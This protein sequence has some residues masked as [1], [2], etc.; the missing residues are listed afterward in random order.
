MESPPRPESK[1]PRESK[2]SAVVA[3]A[4]PL[5]VALIYVGPFSSSRARSASS[6][7]LLT[8]EESQHLWEQCNALF[9]Q[10]K[11][12]EAL[13][14]VLKLHENYP[15]NHIYLEMAAEI[16]DRLGRYPQEAEFWEMYF[17]RA[18]NPVTACPQIAQAYSKQ[19]NEKEAL[20][21]LER[22]LARDPDNSDSIFY[23]AHALELSGQSRRAGELY[24]RGLKIAPN[25]VDL[26]LGLARVWL[27]EG[28]AEGAKRIV[29][30]ALRQSPNNVDALLVAGL[31]YTREE[32]LPRAKKY[33]EQGVALADGYL[34]FHF[35]LAGIAEQEKDFPEAIRQYDRILKDRPNDESVRSKRDALMV[36]Q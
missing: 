21:A 13:P 6:S 35:A 14:G 8:A 36:R 16:Y 4:V 23:L 29:E 31:V 30:A 34:D 26:R 15:S 27:R 11:Y 25:Y 9:R 22:C 32:D 7:T 12:E 5:L 3:I 10:G 28:N 20:S 2:M 19:G 33:L 18:P 24:Q 17:D 1:F